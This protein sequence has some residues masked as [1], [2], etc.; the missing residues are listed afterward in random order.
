[1]LN[2]RYL[3]LVQVQSGKF[4]G[5]SH[6]HIG[7]IRFILT[8]PT[9]IHMYYVA[10]GI[11][12]CAIDMLLKARRENYKSFMSPYAA[13][14]FF[15]NGSSDCKLTSEELDELMELYPTH[16]ANYVA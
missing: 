9:P 16:A 10:G 4:D 13:L 2:T 14:M 5:L 3:K 6:D 15:L 8:L 11:D 1:M 12:D 7:R